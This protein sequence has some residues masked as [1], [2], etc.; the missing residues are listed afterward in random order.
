MP[1]AQ[2]LTEEAF[3]GDGVVLQAAGNMGLLICLVPH[4]G[5][6]GAHACMYCIAEAQG[7]TKARAAMRIPRHE[8]ARAENMGSLPK[9]ERVRPLPLSLKRPSKLRP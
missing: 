1:G 3:G 7:V 2:S 5:A 9:T 4:S 8:T 6:S